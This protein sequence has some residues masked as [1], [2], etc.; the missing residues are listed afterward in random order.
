[1]IIGT[2]GYMESMGITLV[3]GRL[4]DNRDTDTAPRTIIVDERLARHFW[5][6]RDPLRK[7]MFLPNSPDLMHPDANTQFLTVVGVVR[8]ARIGDITGSGNNAGAY[9][10]PFPQ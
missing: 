6:D 10:F 1:Q 8:N 2:P 9:Y 5:Q 4:F 7:R 3:R